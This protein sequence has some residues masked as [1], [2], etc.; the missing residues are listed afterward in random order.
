[1]TQEI[2]LKIGPKIIL[3]FKKYRMKNIGILVF[4]RSN[5]KRLPN[6][7]LKKILNKSLLEIVLIRVKKVSG[8]IPI[9]VNTSQRKSDD[10]II[11]ICKKNKVKYFRGNLKN[12]F[13]RTIDCCKKY[14]LDSFVR[15]NADRPFLDFKTMKKMITFFI[16]NKYDIVTNQYPKISPS[17]LACEVATSKIFTENLNK[18]ISNNE[19]EHIFNF[20]YKNAKNY[21]I[22]NLKDNFYSKVKKYNLSMDTKKNFL[23]VKKI[24]EKYGFNI[25]INM[26][27]K[28]IIKKEFIKS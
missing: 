25:L 24:Y 5:S 4:A 7:V 2:K 18:K 16:L 26:D 15:V 19:Q 12:V 27:T 22:Y 3:S 28:K 17:G 14:N 1:M 10:K 6:K 13:K 21:K 9:I 11:K 8:K 23:K 20:F